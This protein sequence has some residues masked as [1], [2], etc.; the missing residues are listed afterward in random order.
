[1]HASAAPENPVPAVE[2]HAADALAV[3]GRRLGPA[4]CIIDSTQNILCS[5]PGAEVDGLLKKARAQIARAVAAG[6]PMEILLDDDA[7]LRIVPLRGAQPSTF[8]VVVEHLRSRGTLGTTAMRFGLTRRETDVLR[9][10]VA[11]HTNSEIARVL[12]IAECTVSD[13]VKNLFRKVGCSRRTELLTKL[14][15]G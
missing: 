5:S 10:I 15:L 14:F 6:E 7:L 12:Y 11:N 13:H 1:V 8:A 2:P 4:F 3:L 9:L